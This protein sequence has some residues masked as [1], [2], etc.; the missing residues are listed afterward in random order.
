MANVKIITDS[1]AGVPRDLAEKYTI[2]VIPAAYIRYKGTTYIDGVTLSVNEAYD[3]IKKDPDQFS[4]AALTPGYIMEI[5]KELAQSNSEMLHLCL[6]SALSVTHQTAKMATE[7]LSGEMPKVHISV[8]DTK[9][10]ASMQ[11]LIVLALAE[12]AFKGMDLKS[13]EESFSKVRAQTH[14]IMMLD[15]LKYVYRTGRMSKMGSTIASLLKIKPINQLTDEGALEMWDRVTNREKGYRKLIDYVKQKSDGK[16]QHFMVMHAAAPE[17]AEQFISM[18]KEQ[19]EALSVIVSEYS[20]VM[21]YGAGPGCI[22]VGFHSEFNLF[23][24]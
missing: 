13:L 6:S 21:G 15:T 7:L 5:Y 12:A 22:F 8:I 14:G 17:M 16:P 20:P 2:K 24:Q 11:G 23:K 10:V 19:C 1:V 18:L 3:L 9:A 4:T